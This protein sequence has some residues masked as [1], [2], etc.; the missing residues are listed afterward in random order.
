MEKMKN[1]MK[2]FRA[3]VLT[4]MVCGVASSAYAV[5]VTVNPGSTWLGFMNV[6][7]LSQ[8]GG[9]YQFSS[10]WG[11]SDL[12]ATFTGSTLKLGTNNI[13]DP[14]GYWYKGGGGPGAQGNKTM[15]ANMYVETN[16]GSL[17][18]Q[19]LTFTGNVSSNTLFGKQDSLGNTW[20][21]VAFI[22]DFAPDYSSAV[23][24]AIPLNVG[25][26]SISLPLINDPARHVQYGFQTIGSCVWATDAAA[27]G[28]IQIEPV[29]EPMT[30]MAMGA[31]LAMLAKRRRRA[32]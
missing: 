23:V 16:D 11:T 28:N 17:A 10:P 25:T 22:K 13:G 29:P 31:G 14:N 24:T 18:G 9:A 27:F 32:N 6:F 3:V 30:F 26:F 12:T 1:S 4:S 7:N 2:K 20:T 15:D 8:D 21:S 5:T 19:T